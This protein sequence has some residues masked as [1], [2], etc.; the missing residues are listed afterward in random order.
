[1]T[2][3]PDDRGLIATRCLLLASGLLAAGIA[4]MSLIAPDVFYTAYGI[5]IGT[6]IN[7]RNELKASAGVLLFAGLLTLRGAFRTE[8]LTIS[9]RVAATVFLSYGVFRLLSMMADG[10]P[11]FALILAAVIELIVGAACLQR[12]WKIPEYGGQ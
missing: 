11:D 5:E 10:M 1:M 12:L 8:F 4:A 2:L 9:L 7:L 6:D 3:R